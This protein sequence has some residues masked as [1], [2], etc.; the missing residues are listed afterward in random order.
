V[1]QT[2][3]RILGTV[4]GPAIVGLL[5]AVLHH[6]DARVRHEVVTALGQV[7]PQISRPLLLRL[8]EGADT[9][10]FSSV[11]HQLSAVRNPQV[12]HVLLGKLLNEGFERRPIEEKRAI[13]LA[14]SKVAGD[15]VLP[16]LE[17]ELVR[18][19]WLARSAEPHRQAIARCIARIGT[20]RSHEILEQGAQSRRAPVRK[21]CQDAL[22]EM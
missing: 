18:G 13:Y 19:T 17:E 14:L 22:G 3:V 10:T 5:E 8:I 15:E 1:V 16:M 12:A 7:D 11:L 9:R 2:M 4:G 6:P 21:A 20:E